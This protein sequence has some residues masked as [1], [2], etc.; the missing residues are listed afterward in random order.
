MQRPVK[1]QPAPRKRE[2]PKDVQTRF[3]GLGCEQMIEA[4]ARLPALER[5][6]AIEAEIDRLS[7]QERGTLQSVVTS[8]SGRSGDLVETLAALFEIP[9]RD[10]SSPR[11]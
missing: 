8:M 1:V 5:C 7:V 3:A 4:L 11:A 2:L 9:S 6:R 10:G